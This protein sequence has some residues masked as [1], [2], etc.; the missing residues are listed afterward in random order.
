MKNLLTGILSGVLFL[1]FFV[2]GAVF[3]SFMSKENVSQ[4]ATTKIEHDLSISKDIL[5]SAFVS[6]PL[7]VASNSLSQI[8]ELKSEQKVQI[9]ATFDSI[10]A[11]IKQSN[12][13]T[14]GEYQILPKYDYV[15]NKRISVGQILRGQLSCEIQ[16]EKQKDYFALLRQID[17]ILAQSEYVRMTVAVLNPKFDENKIQENK[18]TMQNELIQLAQK[19]ADRFSETL[20]KK[21]QIA[22]IGI[23]GG[24]EPMYGVKRSAVLSESISN[25]T[26]V[27]KA[28]QQTLMANLS[29][30]CK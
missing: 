23:V 7:F 12:I 17:A 22:K 6:N 2:T 21:C 1:L 30:E 24:F 3:Y 27:Q 26:P 19:E 14:G 11:L 5:P 13:C 8:S 9:Q 25:E 28:Q 29:L 20:S 4:T 10:I 18:I 15:D 16:I